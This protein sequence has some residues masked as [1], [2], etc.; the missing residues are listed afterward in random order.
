[1]K[2]VV[3]HR[4]MSISHVEFLRSL[5]AAV[6]PATFEVPVTSGTTP[7][8][9]TVHGAPGSVVIRL[10]AQ[11]E[12]RIALLCLPVTDVEIELDGFSEQDYE[13]FILRFDRAFQ[14][15]GG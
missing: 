7:V 13:A 5:V 14:R 8:T 3:L 15:G 10:S 12:R 6:T 1:M 4:E 2:P 11:R 9:I